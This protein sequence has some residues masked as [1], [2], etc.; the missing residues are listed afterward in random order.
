MQRS[1]VR[2]DYTRAGASLPAC[3]AGVTEE[4]A[5]ARR[6]KAAS[7]PQAAGPAVLC[8]LAAD[9]YFGCGSMELLDHTQPVCY[10]T[11]A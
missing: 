2:P 3:N 6:R 8:L 1:A 5:A 11:L 10:R 7:R 4:I 9:Q